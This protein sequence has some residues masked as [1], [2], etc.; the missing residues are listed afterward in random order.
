MEDLIPSILNYISLSC[1]LEKV[2]ESGSTKTESKETTEDSTV[3]VRALIDCTSFV[4]LS[5]IISSTQ[6]KSRNFQIFAVLGRNIS[7]FQRL[8]LSLF[9]FWFS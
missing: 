7:I 8:I 4:L 2:E 3:L 5:S 9:A 1:I 6:N